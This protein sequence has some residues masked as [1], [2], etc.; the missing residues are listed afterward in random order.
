MYTSVSKHA[1]G[2]IALERFRV[3]GVD[4]LCFF[5]GISPHG[6]TATRCSRDS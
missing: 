6:K 4:G 2:R 3:Y 5:F 1:V